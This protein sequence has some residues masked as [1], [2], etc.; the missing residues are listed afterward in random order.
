MYK[1]EIIPISKIKLNPDNPRIIKDDKFKEL[2]NSIKEFPQMLLIRPIV[3]NDEM[4]IL[5]GNQRLNAANE[6]GL[7][8][9]PTIKASDLT[10]EQQREFIIKDNISFGEWDFDAISNNWDSDEINSFG[11]DVPVFNNSIKSNSEEIN[12][13]NKVHVLLSFHPDKFIE[14]EKH[15]SD[16]KDIEE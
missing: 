3:V 14:L 4:M 16:I 9:V 11:L 2:I 1:T 8:E 10:E 12:E 5:G 6:A 13:Y 15:L 7:K